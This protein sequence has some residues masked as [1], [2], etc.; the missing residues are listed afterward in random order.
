MYSNIC[1][2][3]RD[4]KIG[5]RA[6][7]SYDESKY[8]VISVCA[9]AACVSEL[10]HSD[11]I[12]ECLWWFTVGALAG[13]WALDWPWHDVTA[14]ADA[15]HWHSGDTR[16][17]LDPGCLATPQTCLTLTLAQ[18]QPDPYH[19]RFTIT[20]V[21]ITIS[22]NKTSHKCPPCHAQS[23]LSIMYWISPLRSR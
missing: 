13:D 9:P 17:P 14:W 18:P 5:L 20:W 6:L 16:W 21:T 23:E 12:I 8:S 4:K 1:W 19:I 11:G 2:K 7:H 15:D 22:D 10:T 3:K